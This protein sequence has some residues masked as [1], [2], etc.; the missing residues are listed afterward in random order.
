M[1]DCP[2]FECDR[3]DHTECWRDYARQED[4]QRYLEDD[5]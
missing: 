4:E 1:G 3:K 2:A 5:L